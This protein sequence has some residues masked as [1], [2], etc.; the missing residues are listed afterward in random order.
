MKFKIFFC[1]KNTIIKRRDENNDKTIT[2]E[3][4]RR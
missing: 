4:R 2:D 3:T 1:Q